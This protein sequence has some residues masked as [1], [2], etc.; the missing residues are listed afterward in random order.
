MTT[1]T[2]DDEQPDPDTGFFVQVVLAGLIVFAVAVTIGWL[3]GAETGSMADWVAAI[4]TFAGFVAAVVAG[5]YAYKALLVE[6]AR[7]RRRDQDDR[8]RQDRELR[9]QAELVAVWFEGPRANAV[10]PGWRHP[11]QAVPH[12]EGLRT[13]RLRPSGDQSKPR[14]HREGRDPHR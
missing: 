12:P 9:A 10:H 5:R 4:A 13:Q 7:D 6:Q 11:R 14:L 2:P 8:E 1:S 3:S